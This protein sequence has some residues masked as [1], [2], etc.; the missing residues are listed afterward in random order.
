MKNKKIKTLV[1]AIFVPLVI[2]FVSYLLTK[3]NIQNYSENVVKLALT[4]PTILFPIVWTI[5]YVLMGISSYRVFVSKKLSS[6]NALLVYVIQLF[7]NF[8][9][10]I[11][12]FNLKAYLVAFIW[13]VIMIILIA[14]MVLKFYKIDKFAG[15]LQIPYL[16][17]S[18][19]AAYLNFNVYLL[20][21]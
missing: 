13:L 14:I 18:L 19:F 15:I 2:G 11:I 21:M 6:Q 7:F 10:S 20:N 5:L 16:L 4:P 9:W 1:I 8:F 12:F 17:W 3:D